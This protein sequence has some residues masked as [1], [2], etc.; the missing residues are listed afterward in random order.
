MRDHYQTVTTSDTD[1]DRYPYTSAHRRNAHGVAEVASLAG[2]TA[3]GS[4][5]SPESLPIPRA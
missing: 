2:G 3:Y 4:P 5:P 1:N